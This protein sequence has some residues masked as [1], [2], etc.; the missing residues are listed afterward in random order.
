M[1][2]G[3]CFC[4]VAAAVYVFTVLWKLK[5]G[6]GAGFWTATFVAS[7]YFI[8]PPVVHGVLLLGCSFILIY[9]TERRVKLLPVKSRVVLVTG[10]V[11][12]SPYSP[13]EGL[14]WVMEVPYPVKVFL[15][16]CCFH[17]DGVGPFKNVSMEEFDLPKTD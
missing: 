1:E 8:V 14:V 6:C 9:I 15:S 12:C 17:P 10:G 13:I 7:L 4:V 5:E 16:Q 11:W 2:T 3:S